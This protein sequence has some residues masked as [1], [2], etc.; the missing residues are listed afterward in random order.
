MK[1]V[2]DLGY[3]IGLRSNAYDDPGDSNDNEKPSLPPS[4]EVYWGGDFSIGGDKTVLAKLE[5]I[6]GAFKLTRMVAETVKLRTINVLNFILVQRQKAEIEALQK[7]NL[8][9]VEALEKY[10]GV[11]R[12]SDKELFYWHNGTLIY[13]DKCGYITP[14]GP[15][16]A[17]K[18]LRDYGYLE[19]RSSHAVQS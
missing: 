1:P 16:I 8:D 19:E 3:G 18:I 14:V 9:L 11:N 13:E 4:H 6:D 10:A 7:A 5:K 2:D 15:E 17:L 12:P